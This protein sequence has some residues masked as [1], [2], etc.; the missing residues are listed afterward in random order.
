MWQVF[1]N[2]GLSD[3]AY[4]ET[5]GRFKT[6]GR[7]SLSQVYFVAFYEILK[8]INCFRDPFGMCPGERQ[9]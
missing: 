4:G 7:A 8:L 5:A 1:F 9:F 6:F 2:G 3:N